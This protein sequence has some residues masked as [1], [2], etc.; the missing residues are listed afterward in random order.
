MNTQKK[1]QPLDTL[2]HKKSSKDQK[3]KERKHRV[4]KKF[5]LLI[6]QEI[7]KQISQEELIETKDSSS[8]QKLMQDHDLEKI[9][10]KAL[11]Q[12]TENELN[13]MTAEELS[14]IIFSIITLG[15]TAQ[16]IKQTTTKTAE[17]IIMQL[18]LEEIYKQ[19]PQETLIATKESLLYQKL[20][21][22]YD[23]EEI[24]KKA[25]GQLPENELNIITAEELSKIIFSIITLENTSQPIKQTTTKNAEPIIMQLPQ[26]DKNLT[27][28]HQTVPQF[29]CFKIDTF[30]S[31]SDK[32]AFNS[33][34]IHM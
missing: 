13:I 14:K 24:I 1:K 11:G 17:P 8:Y 29:N 2:A 27:S 7:S 21:Q 31:D 10:K 16:P 4:I 6:L 15:N 19:I 26:E 20:M 34:N 5:K 22:D 32:K 12:L 28:L 23:L 18:I 3:E 30:Q 25:L 33:L 9:T